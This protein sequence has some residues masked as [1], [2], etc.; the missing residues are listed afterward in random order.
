M[1]A[2]IKIALR[3]L[4]KNARRSLITALA[5]ALGFAAVNLFSGF[6]EYMYTGNREIAIYVKAQ[7]HLT[8]FKKGFLE[9]SQLD[10]A[11]YLLT[12][13]EIN[14]IEKVCRENSAIVYV[15]PQLMVSGLITNGKIS[16]VFIGQGIVPSATDVFLSRITLMEMTEIQEQFV[17]RKLEDNKPH[18]VGLAYGLARLLDLKLGSDAVAF[19]NTVDGQLNALNVEVFN[20]FNTSSDQMN[21]KFMIVPFNFTQMLYDTDG[22]DRMAVLLSKTELTEPI[23][24]QLKVALANHGLDLELKTWKEMSEWYRRVKE[25]YDVIFF[26]LFIL[27]FIIVVMSVINT[28][29]MVVLERTREIGTL[30]ALGLKRKGVL[31]LF[32]IECGLLGFI[33]TLWGMLMTILGWWLVNLIR[34]TWVPPG[35]TYRVP[36]IIEFVPESMV[37]SFLFLF[38]LCVIVSLIPARRAARG[39][40]VDAL[41][42]V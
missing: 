5:I 10:P 3:N 21:D 25:M 14:T 27:V 37:S 30:R 33:G 20:L 42:H 32:A 15:T 23:R 39:N 31:L 11:R 38:V 7:G 35:I 16:T 34:L 29:S 1:I 41:G 28:M 18:G 17:G 8:I 2:W 4:I 26:Y 6:T 19:T 40:I 13:E 24:D 12:A 36:I 22:A 9:K